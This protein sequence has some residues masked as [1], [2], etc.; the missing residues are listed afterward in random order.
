MFNKLLIVFGIF[1]FICGLISMSSL[2]TILIFSP[3][4]TEC[5]RLL[6][7]IY[8]VITEHRKNATCISG[9]F[10][11]RPLIVDT[12]GDKIICP[13]LGS[14]NS[15]YLYI[16]KGFDDHS[17]PILADRIYN[18]IEFG[19]SFWIFER[20]TISAG[21]NVVYQDGTVKWL[22]FSE[23]QKLFSRLSFESIPIFDLSGRRTSPFSRDP[24]ALRSCWRIR[25]QESYMGSFI[26]GIVL[27]TIGLVR[28]QYQ[29][30]CR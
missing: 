2:P 30:K 7:L 3:K 1:M 5:K 17:L 24:T 27:C 29:K 18:H 16:P 6:R 19:K 14:G 15:P 22:D 12:A 11:Y 8:N 21:I 10:N 28:I 9:P 4:R 26:L 25:F 23:A 13:G 20:L